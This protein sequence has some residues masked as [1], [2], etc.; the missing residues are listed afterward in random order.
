MVSLSPHAVVHLMGICG[1]GMGSLAGLL[2]SKGYRVQ[3]SDQNIYPPMSHQLEKWEIPVLIG[4]KAENLLP[5]PDLVIVGNAISRGN[6]EVETLLQSDIPYL[7]FPQAIAEFFLPGKDSLVVAG[8]HGKSTTSAFLAHLLKSAG[9]QPGYLIGAVPK[10]SNNFELG[11]GKHFVIEGDEYDTAF[12]DKKSKFLHYQPTGVLLT[13]IEFDHADI[14]KNFHAVQ[15]AFR[16]LLRLIPPSGFLVACH[17]HPSVLEILSESPGKIITYGFHPEAQV[18]AENY[19]FSPQGCT[20]DL[21]LHGKKQGPFQNALIG[22][23]NLQNTLG[24]IA[25]GLEL[26]LSL[27]QIRLALESFSGVRRRQEILANKQFMVLDDFAHHPTAITETIQAVKSSYP[28]R[29]VL[30]VFEP[31]SN[32]SVRNY[33][34]EELAISLSL[35]DQVFIAPLHRLE[36]IPLSDRLDLEWVIETINQRG[37]KAFSAPISRLE[38]EIQKSVRPDDLVLFMSNGGFDNLPYRIAEY[39]LSN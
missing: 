34:Q 18:R 14:F 20:F 19:S 11:E 13:S 32:T 5:A 29:R 2:K 3:G 21:I 27:D 37:S 35:A 7:S 15:Q 30:A 28:N 4:Y 38:Q 8:T 22:K 24:V 6:P 23:H 33:F 17:D 26:E 10:K 12:F 1:T 36:K 39:T 9:L 31:R 25:V 16:E